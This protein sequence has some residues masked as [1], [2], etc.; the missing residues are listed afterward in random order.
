[1]QIQI[2]MHLTSPPEPIFSCRISLAKGMTIFLRYHK[3]KWDRC[4]CI[5]ESSPLN[6]SHKCTRS[7]CWLNSKHYFLWNDD[8]GGF[9]LF[10]SW[11]LNFKLSSL[12]VF[13]CSER[14]NI[15]VISM[16]SVCFHC[17]IL[18]STSCLF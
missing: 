8:G 9:P 18:F 2:R 15:E 6:T 13:I 16:K 10:V 4:A 3:G 11:H 14:K 5:R 7:S 1:M 12:V 17:F